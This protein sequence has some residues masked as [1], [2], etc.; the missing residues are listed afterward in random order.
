MG[1]SNFI[2]DNFFA[3]LDSKK[4]FSENSFTQ[5]QQGQP[6]R[7]WQVTESSELLV[8]TMQTI[9]T[10]DDE[11]LT[12]E[13][14]TEGLGSYESWPT[15]LGAE[16]VC[17][18]GD[19]SNGTPE[20]GKV[21][22]VGSL[23]RRCSYEEVV[24]PEMS[25]NSFQNL[26]PSDCL[27]RATQWIV[28][29]K[30][31]YED[32]RTM[33]LLG[34]DRSGKCVCQKAQSISN[35]LKKLEKCFVL[36]INNND[37]KQSEEQLMTQ[38]WDVLNIVQ[39]MLRMDVSIQISNPSSEAVSRATGIMGQIQN[40]LEYVRDL[41]NAI[42]GI[43]K[44]LLLVHSCQLHH[45]TNTGQMERDGE[46]DI[47]SRVASL[48]SECDV[49]MKDD[50]VIMKDSDDENLMTPTSNS[51]SS[52]KNSSCSRKRKQIFPKSILQPT[53]PCSPP[54]PVLRPRRTP[55]TS[56]TST[57]SPSKRAKRLPRPTISAPGSSSSPTAAQSSPDPSV[58][59]ALELLE[60]KKK[61]LRSGLY[62]WVL[63]REALK[64]EKDRRASC[65]SPTPTLPSSQQA[66]CQSAPP[67]VRNNSSYRKLSFS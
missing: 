53:P 19:N 51:T 59:P 20:A 60:S 58:S 12:A 43:T 45:K 29:L 22:I 66:T 31:V 25:K 4:N 38:L 9:E 61:G 42:V 56:P 62:Q 17:C 30:E 33:G 35:H 18:Q 23:T 47:R 11:S 67:I 48:M 40:Y 65:G 21:P 15:E 32:R 37:C 7:D 55:P 63:W 10:A 50:D 5:D 54:S 34:V 14:I 36:V 1:K 6:T 52:D 24:H 46:G 26:S 3:Q 8:V 57:S 49:M 44:E 64:G 41:T 27:L 39:E 28:T 16:V 2:C 13:T